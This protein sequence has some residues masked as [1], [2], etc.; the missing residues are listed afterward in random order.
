[1]AVPSWK[2]SAKKSEADDLHGIVRTALGFTAGGTAAD[3]FTFLFRPPFERRMEEWMEQVEM[4]LS[5]LAR[6]DR[7]IVARLPTNETFSSV[8]IASSQA[9]ART[10]N[11][12]KITMLASAVANSAVGTT[13]EAD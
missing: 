1:M 7:E 5:H 4:R 11:A 8:F 3:L 12:E 6:R 9:A 13:V 10:S 2:G